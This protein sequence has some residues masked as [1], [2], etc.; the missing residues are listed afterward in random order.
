MA[1]HLLFESDEERMRG[2][3]A[4]CLKCGGPLERRVIKAI[5]PPRLVCRACGFV[6]FLDPKVAV[7]TIVNKEG[8][9]LLIRRGIEPGYGRWVFPGGF[10]DRGELLEDAA[11][12]EVLEESG[13]EIRITGLLDVYSSSGSPV[14]VIVYVAEATGGIAGAGDETLDARWFPFAEIPWAEL[15]FPSTTLALQ[16]FLQRS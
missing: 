3:Y 16:S 15:A 14:V 13:I 5:E 11:V 6:L 1:D 12:R 8:R 9:V 4:F 10:V 2:N 7:G